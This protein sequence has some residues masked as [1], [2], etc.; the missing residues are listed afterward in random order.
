[1]TSQ[2][3]R[4]MSSAEF[5]AF[6]RN[7]AEKHE[8]LDGTVRAMAGASLAHNLIMGNLFARLYNHGAGQACTVLPSDM[9]LG[10]PTQ[11]SYVYPDIMVVCGELQFLDAEQDTLLN[12][13]LI[14]EILSPSTESYDRGKKAQAYRGI[15]S[16]KEYLLVSQH[17]VHIEHVV[18]YGPHQWLLTEHTVL[19]THIQLGSMNYTLQ[20]QDVY[21]KVF[22]L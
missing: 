5:L 16:L 3:Q 8:Y 21:Q 9:R 6:E 17:K 2:A 15:P 22:A 10:L 12:P 7:Q 20:L 14:I 13:V 11:N 4:P 18:R 1:M 19:Q